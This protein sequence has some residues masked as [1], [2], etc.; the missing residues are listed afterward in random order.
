MNQWFPRVFLWQ[1]CP[2]RC[3]SS[4][5]KNNLNGQ[6]IN[7]GF[8]WKWLLYHLFFSYVCMEIVLILKMDLGLRVPSFFITSVDRSKQ[9][10]AAK[11][12][13]DM[14]MKRCGQPWFNFVPNIWFTNLKTRRCSIPTQ[15]GKLRIWKIMKNPS[16]P[17]CD[18][19]GIGVFYLG[20]YPKI[21]VFQLCDRHIAVCPEKKMICCG[22]RSAKDD[23]TVVTK[24]P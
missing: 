7:M 15:V 14:T 4:S 1:I 16:W 21:A 8:V 13:T 18:L 24:A 2:G 12:M 3:G 9:I 23:N 20:N 22:G 5:H 17:H 6:P 10:Q 19:T 11:N